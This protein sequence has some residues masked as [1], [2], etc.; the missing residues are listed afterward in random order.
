MSTKQT[1]TAALSELENILKQLE[2]TE[3]V[4][5]DEIA[6]K[7]ERASKLLKFC[8]NH[9]HQLDADLEK[10]IATLDD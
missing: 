9:L 7:V 4:N 2:N 6:S 1:Y 3:E 8:K 10:M 5:M